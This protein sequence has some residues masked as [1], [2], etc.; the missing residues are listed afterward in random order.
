MTSNINALEYLLELLKNDAGF[1][2]NVSIEKKQDMKTVGLA[3]SD[4]TVIMVGY[5]D[6]NLI[7]FSLDTGDG[8][9]WLHDLDMTIDIFTSR[10]QEFAKIALNKVVAV[11]KKNIQP[12]G[13]TAGI[14]MLPGDI[15]P[16]HEEYRNMF[17]YQMEVHFKTF[18]P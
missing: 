5:G 17:R 6:E 9:D 18:N 2:E 3:K 12:T 13:L 11:L 8:I 14:Q 1:E 15:T 16:L 7:P 10:G 4:Y